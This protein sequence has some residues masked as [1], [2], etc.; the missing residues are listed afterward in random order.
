MQKTHKL[1]QLSG[2]GNLLA[3][4]MVEAGKAT[5]IETRPGD[6]GTTFVLPWMGPKE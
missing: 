2:K 6:V 1:N 5:L 4:L 3:L